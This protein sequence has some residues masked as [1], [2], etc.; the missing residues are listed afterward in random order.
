[1]P[2]NEY[3]DY[4]IQTNNLSYGI[5]L[6]NYLIISKAAGIAVFYSDLYLYHQFMERQFSIFLT[7]SD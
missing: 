7:C 1:M 5:F 4:A 2:A 6:Y 3:S